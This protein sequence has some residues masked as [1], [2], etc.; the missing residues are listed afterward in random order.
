MEH[1]PGFRPLAF[2]FD[3]FILDLWGV[4][5][6]GV[7]PYPGA[8]ECLRRLKQMGK[9]AML[10]S[11]APRRS[12][13]ALAA[14]RAMGI[15]DSLHAG[16]LTSGEVCHRV[17]REGSDPWFARLGKRVFHLGPERD[18]SVLQGLDLSLT[19]D[20]ASAD[21]VLNTGPDEQRSQTDLRAFEGVLRACV[22]Q[23]LPML[24][25]N[26]DLEVIRGGRRVLCAGALA[27]RYQE[28]GGEVRSIGKPDPAVYG[29]V[30]GM[31]ALPRE[32]VLALGDS[33]RTDIAGATAAGI[34]AC[35]VLGGIHGE[36]L[37]NDSEAA[38][39]AARDAG[40]DPI[41]TI[42]GFIW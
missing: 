42:P 4:V 6:D 26:P 12:E 41:A 35:W 15:E 39:K 24:C 31:L 11:N 16:L 34:P 29:P 7:G 2:R 21:F 14:M 10:L 25:T 32:R 36:A 33:L 38:D 18:R 13:V 40:L 8:V 19:D 20:P 22:R 17:L 37:G 5:H 23:R 27:Q 3:G 28:L 1:L 9:P 30:L